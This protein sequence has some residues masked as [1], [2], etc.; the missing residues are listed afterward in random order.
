MRWLEIL[1]Q[2]PP[3]TNDRWN[4]DDDTN[5]R[6]LLRVVLEVETRVI[7]ILLLEPKNA[8]AKNEFGLLENGCLKRTS[9]LYNCR[10]RQNYDE[11]R[12]V[13]TFYGDKKP[14]AILL[15]VY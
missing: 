6:I 2:V 5:H 14:V 4:D 7:V 8:V 3:S 12:L 10:K 1:H 11:V 13:A 9:K 15:A